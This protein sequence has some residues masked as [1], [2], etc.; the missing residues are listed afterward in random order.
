MDDFSTQFDRLVKL[1]HASDFAGTERAAIYLL[2]SL[3]DHPEVLLYLGAAQQFQGKL[4]IAIANL[5]KARELAPTNIDIVSGCASCYQQLGKLEEAYEATLAAYELQPENPGVVSNLAI[6]LERQGKLKDALDKYDQALDLDPN[7]RIALTNRGSLLVTLGK[8]RDGLAHNQKALAT[9]PDSMEMLYNLVD[10]LMGFFK[11]EEALEYCERGLTMMPAH[12]Y[13]MFKKGLALS[14]LERYA[15]AQAALAHAQIREPNIIVDLLPHLRGGSAMMEAYVDARLIYFDGMY[16]EQ[17][18]CHWVHR[19]RYMAN[20][21]NDIH[22]PENIYRIVRNRELGFQM[23]S[24]PLDAQARL[25]LARSI[26]ECTED[27]AWLN[28]VPP[29]DHARNRRSGTKIRIG[30]L[31]PDLRTHP[32]GLLSRRIY[33]LHDRDRFEVYAYSL[34]KEERDD[35][36]RD[37]IIAGCD[38]YVDVSKTKTVDIAQ[39]IF[40][41][42]IDILVDLAGYTTHARVEA[43][44]LRPAPVQLAYLGF[45]GTMGSDFLDYAIVDGTVA[46]DADDDW[47]ESLIRLPNAYCSYDDEIDNRPIEKPRSAF[48]LDEGQF[49]LC[50]FNA[51]YK[52]EPMIFQS[53]INILRQVDNAVLWLVEMDELNTANIIEKA[54]EAGVAKERLIFAK[55][56]PHE[57]HWPRYQL[58]DL[59]LDTYWHNAHT[60]AA[61]AL[62]QGLP[63]LTCE[64]PVASSRL[65]SSLLHALDMQDEL[66]TDSLEAFEQKAVYYATNPQALKTVRDK[67]AAN[68][69]SQPLFDTALTVQHLEQAYIAAWERYQ[70]GLA[71]EAI[72]IA[73]IREKRH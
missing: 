67:L 72:D 29:F 5:L 57:E 30:Y 63:V 20:L 65:A 16:Q 62:W 71:P 17:N 46:R 24:L 70:A 9:Y 25:V 43:L 41:D 40:D 73:D 55:V 35:K 31:S 48:G 26:S 19:D 49:V 42:Q 14:C 54:I 34:F 37:S 36:V 68:R 12:G 64:G 61:D 22:A 27:Y 7:N 3:P 2:Q 8:R 50:C 21:K 18:R 53:W 60:T 11:Y 51:S 69:Y 38:H 4:E 15:E 47:H 66:V 44:A 39:R 13:L 33:G 58:A 6:A 45:P 56:L 32:V 10:S 23:F 52:I 1:F 59:F 28:G